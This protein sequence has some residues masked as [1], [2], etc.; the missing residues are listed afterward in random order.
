MIPST[1]PRTN[2]FRYVYAVVSVTSTST[3]SNVSFLGVRTSNARP[4]TGGNDTAISEAIRA[5]G[6]AAY[7]DAAL[8]SLVLSV[9]PA[10]ASTIDPT[11]NQVTPLPNTEDRSFE[12]RCGCIQPIDS[13]ASP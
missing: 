2:G 8:L 11:T 7:S 3:L 12:S 4:A 9:K 6:G 1:G 13:T 10:Q 5:P